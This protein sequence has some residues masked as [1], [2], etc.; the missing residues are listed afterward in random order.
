MEYRGNFIGGEWVA[1]DES[2]GEINRENPGR[3]DERVFQAPWCASSVEAATKS[4]R[5]ALPEW[6]RLG[7]E[8]RRPYLK[9]LGEIF[10]ER[11]D[12]IATQIAREVGK[13]LWEA[14][15]EAGALSAKIDIMSGEG[16][17]YVKSV[18]PEGLE[19]G[20]YRHRPLGVLGVLGPFNFPLHLPNGHIVPALLTGNTVVVK[21]SEIAPGCMQLYF[22][23]IEAAGLPDGVV[24]MVQGPGEVGAALAESDGI[25][26]VLFTGS[27]ETGMRIK[28]ATSRHY[29]KQLAL[30][31]GGKNTSI[32]LE[33]ADIDQTIHQI[34]YAAYM[35]T[36]Q[37]CSAT[38]RV[39]VRKEIAVEFIEAFEAITRR[40]TTG[41]PLDEEAFM[42]PLATKSAY[43]QFLAAQDDNEGSRLDPVV[44]GGK[45]R[46]ELDGYYVE[47]AVWLANE[48]NA[49]GSHQGR[50]LFGP[51][52]VIYVV[53]SDKA[54]AHVANATEFGLAMSVF[55]ADEERFD[56]LGYDLKAGVLNMNRSTCGAS[57]RLPFGGVKKSGNGRPSALLAA[58]YC[59][60]PQ[61]QL[62]EPAGFD[63]GDAEERPFRLLGE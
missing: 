6:D 43:E 18:S 24:N 20:S 38:S 5:L 62:V 27:W 37:R 59:T 26:G 25:N 34:A 11:R 4:A 36:G 51:D 49:T 10:D 63:E 7:L 45:A 23:C 54:A 22:E 53:D 60:Y 48:V 42:G 16:M 14:R 12:E 30:E 13:P 57:S 28:E 29:W 35:T 58:Q 50:E 2:D 47:P 39:V 21:P 3:T 61:A 33:D 32:V 56:E 19:G 44:E 1:C 8:G 55:T 31:M 46:E 40:V 52:V 15:G 9:R 17:D 41:D